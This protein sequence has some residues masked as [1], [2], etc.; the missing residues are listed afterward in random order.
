MDQTF[1][2]ASVRGWRG[3][4]TSIHL[5]DPNDAH[6]VAAALLGRADVIVTQNLRDFPSETLESL[7]LD[8]VGLDEFLL[9]QL[10]LSPTATIM[11]LRAQADAMRR[12]PLSVNQVLHSLERAGAPRF[13]EAAHAQLWRIQ[14]NS[15][16][17]R[18]R[19]DDQ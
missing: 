8:A 1:P 18:A 11:V 4:A 7:G 16:P 17:R 19:R 12:P 9:N 6:V 14:Q 15:E 5:P 13:A 3:L 2:D 10:D